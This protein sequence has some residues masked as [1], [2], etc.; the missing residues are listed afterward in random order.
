MST[1]FLAIIPFPFMIIS[2]IFWRM[3]SFIMP[4]RF[5]D[6]YSRNCISTIIVFIFLLYPSIIKNCFEVI[7]CSK[8][9][10][11]NYLKSNYTIECWG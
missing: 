10:S 7:N 5:R 2:Y 4:S 3:L 11:V 6:T 9:M 8:V 1:I